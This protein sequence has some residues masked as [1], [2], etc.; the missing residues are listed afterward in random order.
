[1]TKKYEIEGATL[2]VEGAVYFVPASELK[3]YRLPKKFAPDF[4]PWLAPSFKG[5]TAVGGGPLGPV[6]ATYGYVPIEKDRYSGVFTEEDF[7]TY[8][9][10]H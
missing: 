3:A 4:R 9:R 5:P 10:V 8:S 2:E 7:I 6:R 1:M